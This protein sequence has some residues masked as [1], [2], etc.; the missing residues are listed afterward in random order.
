[1][2]L[3]SFFFLFLFI[4]LLFL[5]MALPQ[6][7]NENIK[8]KLDSLPKSLQNQND[9]ERATGEEKLPVLTKDSM[10]KKMSKVKIDELF[11]RSTLLPTDDSK[12]YTKEK[13]KRSIIEGKTF[14]IVSPIGPMDDFNKKA[15]NSDKPFTQNDLIDSQNCNVAASQL[16]DLQFGKP[17][18]NTVDPNVYLESVIAYD[19]FCL[20]QLKEL[21]E[22]LLKKGVLD[23]VGI[24]VDSS[25]DPFCGA[26][27]VD[28]NL[29]ATARHCFY[30]KTNNQL[31]RDFQGCYFFLLREMTKKYKLISSV[32]NKYFSQ[33]GKQK[34][35]IPS[36]EDYHLFYIDSIEID[37]PKLKFVQPMLR[38]K[39]IL[40]G[41][42]LTISNIQF[43]IRNSIDH[44]FDKEY[45]EKAIRWSN[46]PSCS[47]FSTKN[48]CIYHGCQ[49]EQG[50]SGLPIFRND[51]ESTVLEVVG[52]H[53][54][55]G[56]APG[57]CGDEP[58][59]NAGAFFDIALL[60]KNQ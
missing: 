28:K 6:N 42:N 57:G 27:R 59:L 4:F 45:Y 34:I 54:A 25:G 55:S 44:N 13:I 51:P 8:Y 58:S 50:Y 10:L 5:N 20:N 29:I 12:S 37:M 9:F 56:F 11:K 32:E 26:F 23:T 40:I 33:F 47:I 46:Q 30:N 35:T 43:I 38:D 36:K 3:K 15:L 53:I 7:Q 17:K 49:C 19:K 60:S 21:P 41:F 1:M 39:L 31:S 22:Y 48:Q 18:S 52:V 2:I 14:Q 16:F 24:L